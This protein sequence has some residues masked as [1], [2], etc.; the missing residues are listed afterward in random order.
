MGI[1]GGDKQEKWHGSWS[2]THN[3]GDRSEG[4][5]TQC[6]EWKN[7]RPTALPIQNHFNAVPI[8]THLLQ[9]F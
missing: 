9:V 2:E 3:P 5:I 6:A 1:R 7:I 8:L 4:H